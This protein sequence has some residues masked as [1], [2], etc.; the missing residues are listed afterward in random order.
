MVSAL[1]TGSNHT[2]PEI[3]MDKAFHTIDQLSDQWAHSVLIIFGPH[4][5]GHDTLARLLTEQL[6]GQVKAVHINVQEWDGSTKTI[7]DLVSQEINTQRKERFLILVCHSVLALA[8]KPLWG[9]TVTAIHVTRNLQER[10]RRLGE[11]RPYPDAFMLDIPDDTSGIAYRV[12][13][14]GPDETL[15]LVASNLAKH[16]GF[17]S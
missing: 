6:G 15:P 17:S 9:K 4:G 5:S 11:D 7:Q 16:L 3:S 10:A 2:Q 13:L 8:T 14:D 12:H 1:P